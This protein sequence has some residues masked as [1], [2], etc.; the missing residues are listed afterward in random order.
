LSF[1]LQ[2]RGVGAVGVVLLI[3][4][5][6]FGQPPIDNALPM[7]QGP[8]YQWH[9]TDGHGPGGDHMFDGYRRENRRTNRDT[10]R[11]YRRESPRVS[12]GWYERP[13]P[14]HLD[15]FRMRFGS[16]VGA[17]GAPYGPTLP[18]YYGPYYTG[19]G[20]EYAPT[21]REPENGGPVIELPNDLNAPAAGS[22]TNETNMADPLPAPTRVDHGKAQD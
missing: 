8:V 20:M 6:A 1:V 11:D 14:D 21:Y 12:A 2:F 16:R 13:Y 3:G 9:P 19:Y 22:V 4:V 5:T 18:A 10:R 15:F 7:G 17:L